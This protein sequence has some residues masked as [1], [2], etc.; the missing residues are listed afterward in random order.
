MSAW[1][2]H[3][4]VYFDDESIKQIHVDT[5]D[6]HCSVVDRNKPDKEGE[7]KSVIEKYKGRVEYLHSA[8]EVK[9]LI[10]R[11]F[12]ESGGKRDWRHFYVDSNDT[13]VAGWLMKYIRIYRI[14]DGFI[15][16]NRNDYMLNKNITR[17]KA[18]DWVERWKGEKKE[19]PEE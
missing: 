6:F 3:K 4:D 9:S 15:V 19:Q 18:Y 1:I 11:W 14:D 13:A 17:C 12:E 2:T 10:D 16:C 7:W 5:R 8:S